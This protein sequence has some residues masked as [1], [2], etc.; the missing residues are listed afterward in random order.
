MRDATLVVVTD[1][2]MVVMMAVRWGEQWVGKMVVPWVVC[3]AA[4][5]VVL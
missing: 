3:S 4:S 5:M 1:A 2:S